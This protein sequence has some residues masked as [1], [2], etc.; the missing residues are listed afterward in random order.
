MENKN[1]IFVMGGIAIV[2]SLIIQYGG[3]IFSTVPMDLKHFGLALALAFLIIRIDFIRK[4][5]IR[6]G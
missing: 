6:R 5:I 4:T 2:Q 3:R 1:F